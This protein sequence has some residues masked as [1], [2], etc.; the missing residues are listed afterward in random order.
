[1]ASLALAEIGVWV[2]AKTDQKEYYFVK[3]KNKENKFN[4]GRLGSISVCAKSFGG[5]LGRF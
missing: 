2:W 1:M 5:Y 4:K 3:V